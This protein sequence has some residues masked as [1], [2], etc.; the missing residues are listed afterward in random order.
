M[1]DKE[2]IKYTFAYSKDIKGIKGF[3]LLKDL[4]SFLKDVPANE[5]KY[6]SV[7]KMLKDYNI[8]GAFVNDKRMII[9]N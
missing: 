1:K 8:V 5:L 4:R 6:C 9:F 3:K 2:E 7:V